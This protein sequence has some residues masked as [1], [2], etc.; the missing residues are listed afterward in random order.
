MDKET[1]TELSNSTVV[2]ANK[3]YK[4]VFIPNDTDNYET[5]VGTVVLYTKSA[6]VTP[7]GGG[8]SGGGSSSGGGGG[9]SSSSVTTVKTNT[10]TNPDGSVTKIETKSDGT[11]SGDHH[12]QGRRRLQD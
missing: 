7:P 1:G 9:G 6:P 5:A 4:W 10:V 3:E 12:R 11:V 2:V 8:S